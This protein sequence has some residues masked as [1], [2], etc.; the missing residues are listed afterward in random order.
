MILDKQVRIIFDAN[1][2]E[3]RTELVKFL[4]SENCDLDYDHLGDDIIHIPQ[5]GWIMLLDRQ[6]LA[7]KKKL[8][9]LVNNISVFKSLHPDSMVIFEGYIRLGENNRKKI[10]QIILNSLKAQGGRF[11][12]M[13]PTR[14]HSDTTYCLISLAKREQIEDNPPDLSRLSAKS[15][16]LAK[17][18]QHFIEGLLQCGSKK[19]L[20]LL[21]SF[22]T[23]K[24]IVSTIINHPEKILKI[25]GFGKKFLEQNRELLKGIIP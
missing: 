23:P 22:N 12:G 2:K 16:Y 6:N 8:D 4:V 15:P 25:K 11:Q 1:L 21:Q 5:N 19:A 20:I 24:E 9:T 3:K 18:Q 14:N 17:I 7:S 10:Q 13:I